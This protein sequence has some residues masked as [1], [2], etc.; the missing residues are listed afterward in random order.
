MSAEL[1]SDT[2]GE[3][4]PVPGDMTTLRSPESSAESAPAKGSTPGRGDT[5]GRFIVIDRLGAGAMGEVVLAYD[6][7][8]HRRVAVKLLHGSLRE[9]DGGSATERMLREARAMARLSHPNVI[10]VFEVDRLE[11][12][13]L[14]IAMEY[15]D[16]GTLKTWSA[17]HRRWQDVLAVYRQAGAGLR[18]A[19]EQG[20]V[21]RD[22]K[23]DNVLIG[24][25]GRVRVTDFGLVGL[26]YGAVSDEALVSQPGVERL[27]S[28]AERISEITLTRSGSLLGT[29]A[30]MAPEDAKELDARSDQF[31]FCV[32]LYEALYGERPFAGATLLALKA[33][34]LDGKIRPPPPAA[35][36]PAW[37]RTVVVRGL[38]RHPEHRW[39]DMES[40]LRQLDRDPGRTWRKAA[41]GG[42]AALSIGGALAWSMQGSSS[43]PPC[44]GG[45]ARVSELW[46]ETRAQG[47]QHGF[48]A[49]APNA[50]SGPY[51][52][53]TAALDLFTTAWA[54]GY[55]DAC[56]AH[57]V[58]GEQSDT[59]F[60]RRMRCLQRRLE[61]VDAIVEVLEAPDASMVAA[62]ERAGGSFPDLR[63]CADV[64]ALAV[65]VPPPDAP[66]VRPVWERL[67]MELDRA[68][69]LGV[70]G[71]EVRALEAYQRLGPEIE[72]LDHAPL[73]ARYLQNYGNALV[74]QERWRD[75]IEVLDGA[76]G[77]AARS[78]DARLEANVWLLLAKAHG[79]GLDEFAVGLVMARAAEAAATRAGDVPEIQLTILYVA[80]GLADA[81]GDYETAVHYAQAAVSAAREQFGDQHRNTSALYGNL[82][83][84]LDHAG[85]LEEAQRAHETSLRI[86]TALYGADHPDVGHSLVNLG[87]LDDQR[88]DHDAAR[89]RYRRALA[90]YEP[91]VGR[92]HGAY[93]TALLN[94]ASNASQ[95]G[96]YDDAR[97]QLLDVL[98]YYGRTRPAGHADFAL[99]HVDLGATEAA[100]GDLDAAQV[101]LETALAIRREALGEEHPKVVLARSALGALL[102]RRGAWREAESQLRTAWSVAERVLP[103]EHA[104]RAYPLTSLGTLLTATDRHAEAEPLLRRAV[105]LREDRDPKLLALSRFALAQAVAE[106]DPQ[107]A[108]ALLS[109]AAEHASVELAAQIRAFEPGLR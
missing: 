108:R 8:L 39:P 42:I 4:S 9:P 40:L 59:L 93:G 50:W 71:A 87:L 37:L 91:T 22:F 15:V 103:S 63:T 70:A 67:L 64:D 18:A 106:R 98:A 109:A 36:V 84:A 58:R 107:Q 73:R 104:D 27:D 105:A 88:G 94:L 33:A 24:G 35:T 74:R 77:V 95:R 13:G 81:Q 19:H 49:A 89:A 45:E 38:S 6:P 47:L 76:P 68:D 100:L 51:A 82:G 69:A 102:V 97:R 1:P 23:P 17:Q 55:E 85:R 5:V 44:G 75:A 65:A 79:F 26:E 72:Q 96:D 54:Q 20:L 12:R 66:D 3:S 31:S 14:F 99:A 92:D 53:F 57:R 32:S 62:A 43:P 25:D 56:R 61:V 52:G 41:Y 16:G 21:H 11:A 83:N 48:A 101:H 30:Y 80:G 78:G 7:D 90:I 28:Q 60:D 10:T 2:S 34:V 29:P 46:N 86:D